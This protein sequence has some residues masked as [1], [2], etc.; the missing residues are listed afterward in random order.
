[1]SQTRWKGRENI[2]IYSE[3][4]EGR[5]HRLSTLRF[6][7][8]GDEVLRVLIH[9]PSL[10]FRRHASWLRASSITMTAMSHSLCTPLL[11]TARSGP[12]CTSNLWTNISISIWIVA[13][14]YI[15]RLPFHSVKC[16]NSEAF[17][18]RSHV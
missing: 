10:V 18:W 5:F 6:I 12:N 4:P 8:T 13:T 14:L 3:D 2:Q 11:R 9:L 17:V 16:Y 7:P 15:A 1:M